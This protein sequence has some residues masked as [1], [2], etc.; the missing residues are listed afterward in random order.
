MSG[1][2]AANRCREPLRQVARCRRCGQD[3]EGETRFESMAYGGLPVGREI[4]F[5]DECEAALAL[6]ERPLEDVLLD[7]LRGER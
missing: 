2:Q 1:A 4:H 5:C 6:S 7:Y 3:R